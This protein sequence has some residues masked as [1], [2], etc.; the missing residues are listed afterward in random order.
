MRQQDVRRRGAT[1]VHS[2]STRLGEHTRLERD[3]D[4]KVGR[5]R[6]G[7]AVLT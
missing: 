6:E 3:H 4:S 1:R 2:E 7:D 5:L